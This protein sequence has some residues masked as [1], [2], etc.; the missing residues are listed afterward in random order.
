MAEPTPTL[1]AKSA[2]SAGAA[3][4]KP[5]TSIMPASSGS[6]MVNPLETIAT[7]TSLAGMVHLLAVL[8]QGLGRVDR[9]GPRFRVRENNEN[10]HGD[11]LFEG[12]QH[13]EGAVGGPEVE[14]GGLVHRVVQAVRWR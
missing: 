11:L 4:S 10:I 13:R 14:A 8:P 3:E 5:T 9:A 1:M 12:V 7:T 2:I 6:A